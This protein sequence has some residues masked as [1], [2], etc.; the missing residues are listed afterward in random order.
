MHRRTVRGVDCGAVALILI[1]SISPTLG[2][3]VAG[4]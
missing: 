3:G 1:F 4:R 2:G